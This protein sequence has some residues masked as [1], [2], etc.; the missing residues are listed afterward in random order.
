[1]K[2]MTCF[3][4]NIRY[5]YIIS[6]QKSN[7]GNI[8]LTIWFICTTLTDF[9]EMMMFQNAQMHQLVMERWLMKDLGIFGDKPG[10]RHGGRSSCH[11]SHSHHSH[12]S[13]HGH[14]HGHGCGCSSCITIPVVGFAEVNSKLITTIILCRLFISLVQCLKQFMFLITFRGFINM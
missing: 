11:S 3:V 2:E 13:H 9:G 12:H 10:G 7:V 4:S 5:M 6:K 8:L 1:M 14:H